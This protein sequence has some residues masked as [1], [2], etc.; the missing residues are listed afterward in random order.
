MRIKKTQTQLEPKL[1]KDF[2]LFLGFTNFYKK[3]I[4]N[5]NIIIVLLILILY[6]TDYKIQN[7]QNKN[8]NILSSTRANSGVV[9]E[10]NENLLTIAKLAKSKKFAKI[11]FFEI[12]L[13]TFRVKRLFIYPQKAFIKA[14][15]F[16]YFDLKYYIYIKINA[17][18]Y[19]INRVFNQINLN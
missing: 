12:D 9:G 6:I 15:I 14:P 5:F 3:F 4:K 1:V 7:I 10:N 2:L 19:A 18:Q 11:N 13:L 8:S 17:W 16:G